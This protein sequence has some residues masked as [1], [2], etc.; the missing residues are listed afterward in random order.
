MLGVWA[1][2]RLLRAPPPWWAAA[3]PLKTSS[4][5]AALPPALRWVSEWVK[6]L[7]S[8]GGQESHLD[9]IVSEVNAEEAH[10][11]TTKALREHFAPFTIRDVFMKLEPE[12][13]PS[14]KSKTSQQK[15]DPDGKKWAGKRISFCLTCVSVDGNTEERKQRTCRLKWKAQN[16]QIQLKLLSYFRQEK[17]RNREKWWEMLLSCCLCSSSF[18]MSFS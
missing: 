4:V 13:K 7:L 18:G 3:S 6:A 1:L 12:P 14:Q 15:N 5:P 16:A 8:Q 11:S 9:G 17:K 2:R 10:R